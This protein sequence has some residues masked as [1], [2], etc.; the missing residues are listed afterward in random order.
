MKNLQ[1][2]EYPEY[3]GTYINKVE[4]D[5][6]VEA[7]EENLDNFSNFIEN[8]VPDS[9]YE[10]RYQPEKWSIKEVVQHIIDTER[11]FAYRALRIA[12]F[13]KTPL[14][15]FEENDYVPVSEANNRTMED[16]MREFILVRKSTIVLFES[17]TD[18]MLKSIGT[19]SG[20][21]VSTRAI[22][23]AIS[24]HCIHH[25]QVIIERYL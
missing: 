18:N 10:F 11:I 8:L 13:D 1:T 6:V 17:L 20:K 21:E 4:I 3:F 14:S 12:R 23:Y 22:G 5:N 24:G 19:A 15:G 16:L 25:Q 2:N 9:K 7:L